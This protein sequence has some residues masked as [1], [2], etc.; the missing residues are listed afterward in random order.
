[1]GGRGTS[2]RN[3]DTRPLGVV[4]D[5]DLA[6]RHIGDHRRDKEGGDPF[7]GRVFDHLL[8]LLIDG[9]ESADTRTDIDAEPGGVD[10]ALLL[11]G[12]EAAVIHGLEGGCHGEDGERVLLADE[13][14]VHPELQGVEVLEFAADLDGQVFRG[15]VRDEIDAADTVYKVIPKGGNVVSDGCHKTESG[16]DDSFLHNLS[17]V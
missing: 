17:N 3:V 14:L 16:D 10:G 1:M 13:R 11:S 9:G 4:F 5:G 7:P 6:G 12:L 15:K 8:D 2:R